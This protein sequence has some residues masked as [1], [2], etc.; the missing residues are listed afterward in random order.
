MLRHD[1]LIRNRGDPAG[2][3]GVPALPGLVGPNPVDLRIGLVEVLQYLV[4]E[5][6]L[7]DIRQHADFLG[8]LFDFPS[9]IC[10]F[11]GGAFGRFSTRR[12]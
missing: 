9:H 11:G 4:Y 3:V 10:P 12:L 8:Q 5:L 7:F 2:F 6:Q 1:G